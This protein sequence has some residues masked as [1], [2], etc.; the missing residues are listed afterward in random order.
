MSKRPVQNGRIFEAL[1]SPDAED[2]A[3]LQTVLRYI[4]QR[5]TLARDLAREMELRRTA[6]PARRKRAQVA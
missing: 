3:V 2:I 4:R 6:K 5:V 1:A